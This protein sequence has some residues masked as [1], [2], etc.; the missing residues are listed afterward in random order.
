[1]HASLSLSL[2]LFF[3]LI[4]NKDYFAFAQRASL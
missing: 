4:S 2:S 3:F 1:M